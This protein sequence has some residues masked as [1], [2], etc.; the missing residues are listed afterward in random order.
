MP[1]TLF[2]VTSTVA[3]ALCPPRFSLRM[4]WIVNTVVAPTGSGVKTIDPV[5]LEAQVRVRSNDP[6]DRFFGGRSLL[7]TRT[8]PAGIVS[9]ALTIEVASPEG[10]GTVFLVRFP[11]LDHA[12]SV[13]HGQEQSDQDENLPEL[14]HA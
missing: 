9:D 2:T 12:P 4:T 6:F 14:C 13:E 11:A 8:V 7:G 3:G 5:V 1:G 10:E